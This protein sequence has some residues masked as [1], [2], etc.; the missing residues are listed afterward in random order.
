M[1]CNIFAKYCVNVAIICHSSGN[2]NNEYETGFMI[3]THIFI[4]WY[5]E[6]AEFIRSQVHKLVEKDLLLI[7]RAAK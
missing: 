7:I 2:S 6:Y 3:M 5:A 1:H 4:H